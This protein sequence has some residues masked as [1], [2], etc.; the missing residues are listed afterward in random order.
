MLLGSEEGRPYSDD[1]T[2]AVGHAAVWIMEVLG[3]DL[4]ACWTQFRALRSRSDGGQRTADIE[5]DRKNW[6]HAWRGSTL[7]PELPFRYAFKFRVNSGKGP[8]STVCAAW[9][10]QGGYALRALVF[11]LQA[12]HMVVLALAAAPRDGGLAG[13]ARECLDEVW[14]LDLLLG[15][16]FKPSASAQGRARRW[17]LPQAA[18]CAIKQQRA[19]A[20]AMAPGRPGF[21]MPFNAGGDGV[22][23]SCSMIIAF[24]A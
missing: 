5:A 22:V 8:S 2:S 1:L 4:V 20:E 10:P 13:L 18:V 7:D 19:L 21:W 17:P 15:N 24:I 11:L 16:T 6:L 12:A 3:P 14:D 9:P 23:R